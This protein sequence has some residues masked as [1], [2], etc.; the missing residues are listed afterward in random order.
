MTTTADVRLVDPGRPAGDG[1]R[2][3]RVVSA[4]LASLVLV[5]VA[6]WGPLSARLTGDEVRLRVAPVDPMDP[7]RG[8]YVDLGYPDLPGQPQVFDPSAPEPAVPETEGQ[9]VEDE[10]GTAYVRLTRQ[11]EVWVGEP[12]QRSRPADGLYLTCN[13]ESWRLQCGIESWFLPQDDASALEDAVRNG[14]AIATVKVDARGN[15][16]LIAVTPR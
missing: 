7:F 13:D 8:A 12:V 1:H 14:T 10:R 15:A 6:V 5:G 2:R 11:G 16:A 9:A 3:A 4:V